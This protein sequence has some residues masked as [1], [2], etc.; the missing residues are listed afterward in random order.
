MKLTVL[1]PEAVCLDEKVV[2]VVAQGLEGAFGLRPRH[3]DM[4]AALSPG[5]LA[6]WTPDGVEHFLAVNGG[7][8]IKQGETV[9]V[10]TRMAIP[11]K[12]GALKTAVH[13]FLADMDDRQRQTRAVVARLE[14][15]FIRRFVEFGKN[16]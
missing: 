11:G 4:A 16:A 15:D 14:A 12:L 5:I 2:K 8:L 1:Q 3:L 7:I 13:R 6:Y 9:Q 10:A